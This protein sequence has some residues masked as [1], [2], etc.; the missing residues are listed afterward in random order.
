[1]RDQLIL[2][3]QILASNLKDLKFPYKLNF[4]L[5]YKCN[6][7]CLSC[8]IWKI[9][10]TNELNSDELKSFFERSNKFSWIDVTG[11]EQPLASS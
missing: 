7:K 2:T 4:C 3:K 5:T 6:S 8:D 1:M 11:G 10:S 9:K